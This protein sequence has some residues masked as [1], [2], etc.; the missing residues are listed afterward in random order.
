MIKSALR[1]TRR[2]LNV[3]SG[4]DIYPRLDVKPATRRFGSAYG[5][6][7]VIPDLLHERSV[8]YSFGIGADASFDLEIISYSGASVFAFDPTPRS[9]T[10]VENQTFPPQFNF[11]PFGIADFDG[12]TEFFPP[13][14][15]DHISHS[16]INRGSGS[17]DGIQ[18]PL[19]RLATIMQELAHDQLDILK[20]DIEGAEYAV[21]DNLVSESVR[22]KQ[23]LLEFHHHAFPSITVEQTRQSIDL[24]RSIGYK[25]F[26]VSSIGA[27][28]SFLYQPK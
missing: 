22:P 27:E 4:T 20:M 6:W 14:N 9:M 16:I 24:L 23:L 12:L 19:K 28:Y 2:F 5:G 18:V 15:P 13:Q 3:L 26:W 8:V 7:E 21:I 17:K 25:L 11:Y 10:W 1:N